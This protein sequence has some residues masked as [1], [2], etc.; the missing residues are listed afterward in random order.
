MNPI[1]FLAQHEPFSRLGPDGL[2]QIGRT[3]EIR[4]ARR[5]EVVLRREGDPTTHLG[6][7]RKGAVRLEVEGRPADVLDEGEVYGFPSLLSRGR[8]RFDVIAVEDS[9]LY[10]VPAA[11]FHDLVEHHA[12]FG[13]FF[14]HSLADRLRLATVRQTSSLAGD[15]TTPVIRLASGDPVFVDRDATI[16]EAARIMRDR[17]VGSVLVK[18]DP[19]GIVTD[20]DLR[21]RVLAERRGPDV[22]VR[23]VMSA[24]LKTFAA[25]APLFEALL[26]LLE[27]RIHHLALVREGGI[28]GVVTH[29]DLLR[30]HVKSPS[31]L[32][33]RIDKVSSPDD[34]AGYAE[35]VA[36]MV[37]ALTWSG[38]EAVEVGRIVA[39]LNDAVVQALLV[40]AERELGQPPCPYAWM[41]FGSEG[42][43]E[44]ALITDQ[45]NALVYRDESATA[46]A[47][48]GRFADLVVDGLIRASFPPCR[49]GFMATNWNRS[50]AG[51]ERLFERW[52]REPDPQ[53][54]LEV[55]NFFDF[56]EIHGG[57]DLEPL[58]V[59]VR[60]A[61]RKK[62]FL[63]QLAKASL[64]MRPPLGLFHRI[65]QEDSGV[66]L[67]K[68]GLMPI[69]GVARVHALEAGSDERS[70]LG[71]LRAAAA[72]GTLSEDGAETL[73]EGFRFLFRLRLA[74][75]L[76]AKRRGEEPTNR[77]RLET[78]SALERRHL[79]DTFQHIR[80]MQEA[81]SQRFSTG[82]LG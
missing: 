65:R 16:G 75:Q 37:E 3:L 7:V 61:A 59:R 38:V 6:V 26:Y 11:T 36:G 82:L 80:T 28:V 35:E 50:L 30:H 33:K 40:H 70:T 47:Y 34:L 68:G 27:E 64:G 67:K 13:E 14:L 4:Y 52:T 32:L 46:K 55:A 73:E 18:G 24:P 20:R 49:G 48:F 62:V 5:G 42:R 9:L 45:D 23:D 72:A 22:P 54:L 25:D 76:A 19:P 15:L 60:E 58:R 2:R 74:T 63:A 53:A 79:K 56:R 1:E 8:P 39:S 78:L 57:L 43:G 17:R 77:V 31:Y 44:Q 10:L 71:R 21:S 41:V 81:M 12:A 66:D 69:L 29:T 51:W